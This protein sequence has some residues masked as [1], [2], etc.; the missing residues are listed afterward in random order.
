M[1]DREMNRNLFRNHENRLYRNSFN[2]L[3]MLDTKKLDQ[4]FYNQTMKNIKKPDV[5]LEQIKVLK[6]KK[7]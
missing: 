6:N 7:A 5:K 3:N 1:Q 2:D 4:E